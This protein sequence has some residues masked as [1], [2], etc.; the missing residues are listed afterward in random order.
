LEEEAR[1]GL[2]EEF[3]DRAGSQEV[4]AWV[5][6]GDKSAPQVWMRGRRGRAKGLLRFPTCD[7]KLS[8]GEHHL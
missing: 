1:A 5:C 2:E 7:C 6:R 4:W 8:L 3:R